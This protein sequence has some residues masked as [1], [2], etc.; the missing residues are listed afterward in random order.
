LAL[1]FGAGSRPLALTARGRQR[2]GRPGSGFLR[3]VSRV[4]MRD[5]PALRAKAAALPIA[6]KAPRG[7][8]RLVLR[9]ERNKRKKTR[10]NARRAP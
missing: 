10:Q 4:Q 8:L 2:R 7:A 5:W 6:E 9:Q 1:A 3:A